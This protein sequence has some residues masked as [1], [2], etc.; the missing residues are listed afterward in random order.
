[1]SRVQ[2]LKCFECQSDFQIPLKE[3]TRQIK[4]GRNPEHFFCSLS[5]T[6]KYSNKVSPKKGNPENLIKA[7]YDEFSPFRYHLKQATLKRNNRKL[8]PCDIDLPYLKQ[9]WEE[10]N[11]ICALSGLPMIP[12]ILQDRSQPS[13]ASLDRIDSSKGYIKGNVQFVCCSINLAKKDYSQSQILEFIEQI[14]QSK[15]AD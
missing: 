7:E 3:Y 10:Q 14:K 15:M 6:G 2:P 4:R 9:L 8:H 5:C 12:R 1:M 13:S 11:G